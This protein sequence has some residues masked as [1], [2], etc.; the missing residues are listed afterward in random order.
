MCDGFCVYT[1]SFATAS[2]LYVFSSCCCSVSVQ[3]F[4]MPLASFHLNIAI[5]KFPEIGVPLNHLF[6]CI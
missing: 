3:T 1:D 5:W 2:V 4:Y 6:K